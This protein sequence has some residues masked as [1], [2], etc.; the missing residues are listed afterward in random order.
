MTAFWISPTA[1]FLVAALFPSIAPKAWSY[2]STTDQ[3]GNIYCQ[4][5]EKMSAKHCRMQRYESGYK[6][7]LLGHDLP[8]KA[9]YPITSRHTEPIAVQQRMSHGVRKII[10]WYLAQVD[11]DCPIGQKL[12][13]GE[14]FEVRWVRE[15]VAPSTMSFAEDRKI[16]EKALSALSFSPSEFRTLDSS[17]P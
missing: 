12:E 11:S 13:E 1:S 9:P 15:E 17:A 3:R 7:H 5:A 16:V 4:K 8:I 10:F 2:S 6:C 14:D